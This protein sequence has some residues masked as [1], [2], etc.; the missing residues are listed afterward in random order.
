[1]DFATISALFHCPTIQPY[2][3]QMRKRIATMI[4]SI[5]NILFNLVVWL[6]QNALS[7]H[8]LIFWHSRCRT[9]LALHFKVTDWNDKKVCLK[10]LTTVNHNSNINI[11]MSWTWNILRRIL[12]V[13]GE[14]FGARRLIYIWSVLFTESLS[15]L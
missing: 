7:S 6:L 3:S 9:F 11:V 1:M 14:C 15:F 10:M 4:T 5:L 8:L 13:L 12:P 2:H